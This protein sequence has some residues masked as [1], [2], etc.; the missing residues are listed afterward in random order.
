MKFSIIIPAYNAEKTIAKCIESIASQTYKNLEIIII[1]DGSN[2]KTQEIVLEYMKNDNRIKLINQKNKGVS[3]SRNKGIE[4]AK[5]E[6]INFIDADDYI[7]KNTLEEIE[8]LTKRN[9]DFI[10]YNF[11]Y[12]TKETKR[13]N[14]YEFNNKEIDVELNKNKLYKRF[15]LINNTIPTFTPL[16]F[17]KKEIVK[18]IFFDKNLCYLEDADFYIELLNKSKKCYFK[19]LKNYTVTINESSSSRRISNK[20]N[21]INSVIN[22]NKKWLKKKYF[23]KKM[24]VKINTTHAYIIGLMIPDLYL[25]NKSNFINVLKKI[26]EKE[27]YKN[28]YKNIDYKMLKIKDKML[29]YGLKTKNHLIIK[30]LVKM[31]VI[32]RKYKK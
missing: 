23:D 8:K 16:L 18:K 26:E 21:N 1:N 2:D 7:E 9:Y 22:L 6:Y 17:I 32:Y 11:I 19:D 15:F 30:I 10:R 29:A 31:I 27:E 14:L 24:S 28:I 4:K 20:E 25:Y 3:Y 13:N 12:D 5:G